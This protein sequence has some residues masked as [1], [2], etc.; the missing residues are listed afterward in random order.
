MAELLC[1]QRLSQVLH[2]ASSHGID[3]QAGARVS[4]YRNR[5]HLRAQQLLEGSCC[6]DGKI[7]IQ[8][9][10]DE[11]DTEVGI[12]HL[13][14]DA[15]VLVLRQVLAHSGHGRI[16]KQPG[17]NSRYGV[18]GVDLGAHR[19]HADLAAGW[20]T[21]GWNVDLPLSLSVPTAHMASPKPV[22]ARTR[23]Q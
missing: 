12:L 7:A 10:V 6:F 16:P 17:C 21:A 9:E 22:W 23:I 15:Q 5:H 14:Q 1:F 11:A 19:D 13:L 8:V 18:N 20:N 4:G 2:A 3:N